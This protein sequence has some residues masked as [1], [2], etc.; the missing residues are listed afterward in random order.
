M[1]KSTQRDIPA[2]CLLF[3]VITAFV[4]LLLA[5][6]WRLDLVQRSELK[7]VSGFVESVRHTNLPKA[8]YKLHIE[9]SDGTERHHLTQD[10]LTWSVPQLK[11]IARGDAVVAYVHPD[12]LG[13]K[14]D[15]LWALER[16]G[17][18]ILTYEE[19]YAYLAATG[20]RM[21]P[22]VLPAAI[23]SMLLFATAIALRIRYGAWRSTI[24][25]E[26]GAKL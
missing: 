22:F 5:Y 8:G 21:Q 15:W 24:N 17:Q 20:E 25:S 19:T 9:I 23:A 26:T 11:T 18:V 14:L 12:S 4:P 6:G 3:A 2:V 13:R 1:T 10:D 7:R 16:D